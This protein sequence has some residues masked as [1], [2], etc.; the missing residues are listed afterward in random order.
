MPATSVA[1][2]LSKAD[3]EL[4]QRIAQRIYLRYT[5]AGRDGRALTR[6]ELF[7]YGVI[8]LLEAKKN[9]D[10]E[11]RT[12]WPVFAAYRVE[13]EMLDN[14]RKAPLIRLPHE[15]QR[16]VRRLQEASECLEKKNL[17]TSPENLAAE[18]GWTVS[19]VEKLQGYI[20]TI[21]AVATNDGSNGNDDDK[22]A[23]KGIILEDTN[24]QADPQAN[25]LRRE[26]SELVQHCLEK[27]PD[28]K[29]RIIV[30]AR[31]LEDLTL[32]ELAEAF[33]C[34]IETIRKREQAA[35]QQLKNCLANGGWRGI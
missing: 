28:A 18:L 10:A 35:L 34:S 17:E 6:E 15:V 2:H 14:L 4:I 1:Y 33:A 29:D 11:S 26:L 24:R 8:G 16:Q 31:K 9:F 3:Q 22:G 5:P 27:L 7:H 21:V 23:G 30:K 13:G 32:R 25:L 20:P 19:E 12:P